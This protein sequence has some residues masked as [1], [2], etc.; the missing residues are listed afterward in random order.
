MQSVPS[1]KSIADKRKPPSTKTVG[2]WIQ[3][4]IKRLVADI[5]GKMRTGRA[6]KQAAC[7]EVATERN[8]VGYSLETVWLEKL[9]EEHRKGTTP[10]KHL[11]STR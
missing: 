6:S 5:D 9:L 1:K 7:R 8:H 3:K 2:R 4:E 11:G 10:G